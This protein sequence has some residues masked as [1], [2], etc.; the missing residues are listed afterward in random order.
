[1]GLLDWLAETWNEFKIF[2]WSIVLSIFEMYKDLFIFLFEQ[3]LNLAHLAL[4]GMD[5]YFDG[6]NISA[7]TSL[8][9]PDV[10]WFLGQIGLTQAL[11]MIVTAITIRILLQLIPFTRLGS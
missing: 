3:F 7:Y 11:T 10:S 2:L 1:M 8:I 6:L 9:P 4:N 5:S